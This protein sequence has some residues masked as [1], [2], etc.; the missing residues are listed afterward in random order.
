MSDKHEHDTAEV[1]QTES[2]VYA[3]AAEP[4]SRKGGFV[5][6]LKR[7]WWAYL[8]IFCCGVILVTCLI[9][10]VAVPK[11]AQHKINDAKLELQGVNVLN[12]K[13]DS[14][15]LEINSTITT[16]GSIKAN[17]DAFDGVMYLEDLPEHT[18]FLNVAFPATTGDKHQTVNISQEVQI[19]DHDAFNTFNIWFAA[20]ETLRVTV[21][22]RTKVKPSGLTRKYDVTFK[23]TIVMNGLNLFSGTAVT[24]GKIDMTAKKGQPNFSGTADIP[25]ASYFTL[26][27]GNATFTNFIDDTNIGNLT[28]PNLLLVPGSNKVPINANLNQVAVLNAV[29]SA[30]YCKTGVIPVKLQG[31]AVRNDDA[32][33]QYF[34]DGLAAHN[35]TVPMDIG[36]IIKASL[37]TTI[38]CAKSN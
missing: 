6:H 19:Q 32:T 18:P 5:R 34:L 2:R 13:P 16:D 28:I 36:A 25:N 37:G 9:V 31:A 1:T 4:T 22:G 24:N 33:L 26:D 14:I 29:Q 38:G 7:F 11:I 8:L 15:L 35:Q 23:K 12:A 21:E 30:K 17:I 10:F 3:P 20:N 27:I